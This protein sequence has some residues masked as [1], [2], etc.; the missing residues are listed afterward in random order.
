[1]ATMRSV[2]SSSG[3]ENGAARYLYLAGAQVWIDRSV[4]IAHNK[5]IDNLRRRGRRVHVPIDDVGESLLAID[6]EAAA[7]NGADAERVLASLKGRQRDI[8]VAIS[9]EGASARQVA[10]RL[11]MT[12]GAVR[13]VLHRALRSLAKTF[14]SSP[15]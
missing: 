14:R 2:R 15:T 8:V 6:G 11:G 9:V 12:E 1:M 3:R 13:V 4:T 5:L 10:E 7:M